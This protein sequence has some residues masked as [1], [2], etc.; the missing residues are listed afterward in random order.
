[1]KLKSILVI[2]FLC[3]SIYAQL[4]DNIN[5]EADNIIYS[6]K[7]NLLQATSNVVLT[8]ENLN[9]YTDHFTFNT[10]TSEVDFKKPFKLTNQKQRSTNQRF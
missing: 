3:N 4:P 7:E 5:L 6:K 10:K 2:T 1:M 9:I 8:Y